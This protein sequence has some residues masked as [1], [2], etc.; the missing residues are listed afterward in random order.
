MALAIVIISSLIFLGSSVYFANDEYLN[1]LNSGSF[2]VIKA[3]HSLCQLIISLLP[4]FQ[5]IDLN[6]KMIDHQDVK[7]N[8]QAIERC[9]R[10]PNQIINRIEYFLLITVRFGI[11]TAQKDNGE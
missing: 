11:H 2:D 7:D 6:E 8:K 3:S 1:D 5:I 10:R 4:F 9:G